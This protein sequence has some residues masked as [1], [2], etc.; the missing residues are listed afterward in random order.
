MKIKE[1]LNLRAW[2]TFTSQYHLDPVTDC[3]WYVTVFL[4]HYR[5]YILQ[6]KFRGQMFP[7]ITSFHHSMQNLR[8]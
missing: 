1:E 7:G 8:H 2:G 3:N 6:T 4:E 5:V